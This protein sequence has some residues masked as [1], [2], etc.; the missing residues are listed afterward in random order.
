[1]DVTV[2][3]QV[4]DSMMAQ[5]T[6]KEVI[7]FLLRWLHIL[8][9]IIWIGHLYFFNFVN[10]HFEKAL[11]PAYKKTVVPAMR[12]RALWWF[13]WGAMLTFLSGIL[14]LGMFAMMGTY[15]DFTFSATLRGPWILLGALFGTI[16]WFN[17]WFIIWPNQK[18]IL[19][20]I[21]E[22]QAPDAA[23]VALAGKASRMNV[24][25]SVPLIFAMGAGS[26]HFHSFGQPMDTIVMVVVVLLGFGVA[27]HMFSH[28]AKIKID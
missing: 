11:D 22:G 7:V 6:T 17:V 25:L 26:G 3:A 13:R 1:M 18:K 12:G 19:A 10:A 23:K 15:G 28:S 14:M 5:A 8:A 20:A 21:R 16:M 24:Y 9:G 27:M 2:T 4:T